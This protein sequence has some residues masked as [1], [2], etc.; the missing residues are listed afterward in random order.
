MNSADSWYV[1]DALC[2]PRKPWPA[3]IQ[4]RNAAMSGIPRF[5]V[6]LAKKTASTD[7]R[8]AGVRRAL[9]SASVRQ[10]SVT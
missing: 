5:P 8:P 4:P 3:A 2:A 1:S 6:V 10:N 7:A 9:T